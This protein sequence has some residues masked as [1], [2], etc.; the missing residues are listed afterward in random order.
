MTLAPTAVQRGW[1]SENA[2]IPKLS[3]QGLKSVARP[4]FT[5]QE[6]NLLL[7]YMQTWQHKGRLAVE[8]EMRQLLRDYVE[9]LLY[10]G[11]RHG[12][13]ALG[14]RWCD[15]GWHE[16]DGRRYL[17]LWVDGKTGGRWL[18]AKHAAIEA[19]KRLHARQTDTLSIDFEKILESNIKQLVFA[20]GNGY[21]PTSLNGTFRRLMRDCGLLKSVDGQTRTL[22]SLRHT[23][24]TLELLENST[25]IHTLS[26]QMGNSA[27]MIERHYSKL[28]ATMAAGKLAN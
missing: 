20:F 23:Y 1:I 7:E 11:I 26:K 13:E 9:I 16:A 12:T 14:L 8:H 6:I 25:D 28:T 4:A 10:T 18:I 3:T 5:R 24:A 15:V 27:A 19:F 2:A 22:Y 21:Q 17:R